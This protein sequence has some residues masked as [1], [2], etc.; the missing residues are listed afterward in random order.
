MA[1]F[2]LSAFADEA[3][4]SL[5]AQIAALERNQIGSVELRNIDG[6]S[7]SYMTPSKLGEVKR[8]LQAHD[9]SVYSLGSPIGKYPIDQ[10]FE[11]HLRQ[12][13]MAL[14]AAMLLGA[15]YIRIFSFYVPQDRLDEY[16]PEVIRRLQVMLQEASSVRVT[17][18]HENET[19]I[20]GQMPDRVAD[21]L[22]ALP[23][24]RAI[25]DPAN[26]RMNDADSDQGL[27]VSLPS[28]AYMHVKDAI[29]KE[30]LVVPAGE[31]EG[32]VR[33]ALQAIHTNCQ[34]EVCLTL[35][36]HL[37]M[38]DAY[39]H[40]DTHDLKSKYTFE[41]NDQSFDCAAAALKKIL[42]ELGFHQTPNN[43]WVSSV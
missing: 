6:Q 40:I 36:P 43:R 9:I 15:R 18:C 21:L 4:S 20:Y 1:V 23:E 38:F 24:L 33:A 31:G 25:F 42:L 7:V 27:A 32:N 37:R 10:P 12:F 29:F 39:R 5:S 13:R 26:Y 19:G 34:R 2:F 41:N 35:E 30:Q 16:R 3:G 14:R 22:A 8:A 11:P 28:F 17:L